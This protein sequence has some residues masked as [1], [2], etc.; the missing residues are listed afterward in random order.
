[1][2]LCVQTEQLFNNKKQ[3]NITIFNFI[4]THPHVKGYD[5]LHFL[6]SHHYHSL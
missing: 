2:F 6:H 3:I 4:N 5:G 1:M